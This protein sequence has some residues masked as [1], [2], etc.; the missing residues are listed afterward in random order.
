MRPDHPHVQATL[1][2]LTAPAL[3]SA[4]PPT[5]GLPARVR[6][7]LIPATAADPPPPRAGSRLHA[8]AGVVVG[9]LAAL[10]LAGCGGGPGADG[11][12]SAAASAPPAGKEALAGAVKALQGTTYGYTMKIDNGTVT[13]A[14]D[15]A[16]KRQ[17]RLDSVASG[18]KFSLEGIVLGGGERYFRTSIPAA[19]VN[20]K[21]WYRFDRTKVNHTEIIGLFETADPT[22]S[23][24]FAARVGEA[25]LGDGGKITGTYDLTRGGD[26]GLADRADLA[27]LGARAKAAPFVV[28]LDAQG[29]LA[30]V[31]VTVPSYAGAAE[32]ALT[33]DYRDMGQP[34]QLTVPKTAEI[35]PANAAV[36]NLLNN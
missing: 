32:R 20:A 27:A 3:A 22:S 9:L 6:C 1:L 35:A 11:S 31:K 34:V 19:G 10:V 28:T 21:K 8:V 16:G 18:V 26:L 7:E 33:V 5:P 23:Q 13:G 36:Y 2:M 15:P 4:A 17:A 24:D 12:T 25:H 14:V 29:R 30:S